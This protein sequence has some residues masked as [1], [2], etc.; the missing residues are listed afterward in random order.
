[1]KMLQHFSKLHNFLSGLA[2]KLYLDLAPVK[3]I[4]IS[5]IGF[6]DCEMK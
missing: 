1:M 2:N 3:H 6:P 5:V 4:D